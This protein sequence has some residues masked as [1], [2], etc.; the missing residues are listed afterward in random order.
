[1]LL[2]RH[3]AIWVAAATTTTTAT[4]MTL[5]ENTHIFLPVTMLDRAMSQLW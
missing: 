3:G 1:M 2:L 5:L 4:I